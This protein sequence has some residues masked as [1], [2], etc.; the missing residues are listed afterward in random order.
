MTPGKQRDMLWPALAIIV[1]IIISAIAATHIIDSE[2]NEKV[3]ALNGR[4]TAVETM[5]HDLDI[6]NT[7]SET[8]K[9]LNTLDTRVDNMEKAIQ[10]LSDNQKEET[11]KTIKRLLGAA[12]QAKEPQIA[13]RILNTAASL[14]D[15]LQ[16]EKHPATPEFFETSIKELDKVD[17]VQDHPPAV[18]VIRFTF[19]RYR[20]AIESVPVWITSFKF[21]K[22]EHGLILPEGNNVV[23]G[24]EFD[25]RE[26][27][28]NAIE[29]GADR[30]L[31]RNIV[32]DNDRFDGGTQI[33]DGIHWSNSY[34]V[35]M[36]IIY[37]GGE[38]ELRNVRFVNC[39]FDLPQTK[40]G[41][42]VAD[43]VALLPKSSLSIHRK[44]ISS[45]L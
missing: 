37:E 31:A 41:A 18:F 3:G 19:A 5:L 32:F 34:F 17:Q 22:M 40:H 12:R 42:A 35:G 16:S 20:S 25:F 10:T 8:S 11:Q 4:L 7:A 27:S 44:D 45:G 26:V 29:I 39:T 28:G 43:Y 13:S 15:V 2:I 23:D 24:T 30:T 36:H 9:R 14:V 38:V 1:S 33:L 21:K 6:K